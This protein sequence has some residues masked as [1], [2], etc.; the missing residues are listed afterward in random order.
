MTKQK[1]IDVSEQKRLNEAREAGI[2]E[3]YG[4]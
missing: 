3:D 4:I 2:I 1:V